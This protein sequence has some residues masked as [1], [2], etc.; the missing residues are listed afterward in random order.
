MDALRAFL[1]DKNSPIS[2]ESPSFLLRAAETVFVVS[3]TTISFCPSLLRSVRE[4]SEISFAHVKTGTPI[5]ESN[6]VALSTLYSGSVISGSHKF[7]V[8]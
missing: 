5:V 1:N 4:K 2:R 3:T 8:T 7:T 6:H